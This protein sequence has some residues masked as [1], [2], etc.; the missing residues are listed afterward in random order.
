M[1]F[2]DHIDPARILPYNVRKCGCTLSIPWTE[3]IVAIFSL[4]SFA[5]CNLARA[6]S[7]IEPEQRSTSFRASDVPITCT[8]HESSP[9]C[10]RGVG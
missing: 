7:R 1:M 3:D 10:L 6:A 5:A 2:S 8:V 9:C 4:P